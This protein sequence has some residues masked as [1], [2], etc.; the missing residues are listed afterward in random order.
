MLSFS[1]ALFIFPS[2]SPSLS[3][4]CDGEAAALLWFVGAATC[5][6]V[7]TSQSLSPSPSALLSLV[8]VKQ[9]RSEVSFYEEFSYD[10]DRFSDLPPSARAR[11][12]VS[13]DRFV[14]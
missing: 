12:A 7:Q 13:A 2:L 6:Q 9:P 5:R 1:L 3:L 10:F 4:S 11:R 8:T 14:C